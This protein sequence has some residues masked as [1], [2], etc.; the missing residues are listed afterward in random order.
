M[1]VYHC[2]DPNENPI[3]YWMAKSAKKPAPVQTKAEPVPIVKYPRDASYPLAE[4]IKSK[5]SF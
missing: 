3:P 1:K 2:S 5:H 4:Y